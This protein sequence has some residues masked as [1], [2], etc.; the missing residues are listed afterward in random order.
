MWAPLLEKAWAKVKGTFSGGEGGFMT[1]GLRALTGVPVES[2]SLG[3][4]SNIES[5]WAQLL[6]AD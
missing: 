6:E 1:T 3:R 2:F 5:L 4:I